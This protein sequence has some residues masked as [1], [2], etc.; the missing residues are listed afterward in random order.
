MHKHKFQIVW[1]FALTV[2]RNLETHAGAFPGPEICVNPEEEI[3]VLTSESNDVF[4]IIFNFMYP[5]KQEKDGIR[6]AEAPAEEY[7]FF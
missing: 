2:S 6:I 4:A 7:Q 5:C 3:N 1:H